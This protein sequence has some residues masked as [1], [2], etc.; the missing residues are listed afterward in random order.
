MK[1][2]NFLITFNN[3]DVDIHQFIDLIKGAGFTYCRA[4][5]ERGDSGTPHIQAVFGGK[6][7]RFSVISKL[8]PKAHVEK[9]RSPHDGWTYCGKE[10][11]RVEGPVEFGIP[12]AALNRAG[13]LKARNKLLIEKGVV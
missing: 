6:S 3:P 4:Q 10:E 9:C 7:T 5:L 8:L 11:S 2:K 13:D 12:P 1:S